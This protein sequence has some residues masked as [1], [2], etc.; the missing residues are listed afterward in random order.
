MPTYLSIEEL[1]RRMGRHRNTIGN[2][3][4]RHGGHIERGPDEGRAATYALESILRIVPLYDRRMK[5]DEI[6]R[7]LS[8]GGNEPPADDLL[9][10]LREIRD[11][12]RAIRQAVERNAA[13]E[14]RPS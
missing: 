10:V 11:D 14:D 6:E 12:I 9:T 5:A 3:V 7:E 13:P 2:W 8:R 4:R 1:A